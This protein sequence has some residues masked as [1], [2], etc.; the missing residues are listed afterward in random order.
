MTWSHSRG[1]IL[2]TV[3]SMVIPALL[4]RMSTCPCRSRTSL[5]TRRT[6]SLWPTLPWWML[7]PR[8]AYLSA[9]SRAWSCLV[10][11]AGRD[12]DAAVEQPLADGQPDAA[13]PA[14]NYRD[15]PVHVTHA[16][17]P[18][19]PVWR[20]ACRPPARGPAASR[21]CSRMP[22]PAAARSRPLGEKVPVCPARTQ[23]ADSKLI[24]LRGR[25]RNTGAETAPGAQVAPDGARAP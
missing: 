4:T 25:V 2:R 8:S 23:L 15:L 12:R 5:K 14:S 3:L 17:P 11:S 20:T 18:M 13:G 6:S 10:A 16:I 24:R 1:S 7:T 21:P 22:Q 9:N 19:L